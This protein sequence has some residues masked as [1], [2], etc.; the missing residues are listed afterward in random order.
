MVAGRLKA[1]KENSEAMQIHSLVCK[2]FFILNPFDMKMR[3]TLH[4]RSNKNI[5]WQ[6]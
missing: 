1:K 2:R 6:W 3:M 5:E 4:G